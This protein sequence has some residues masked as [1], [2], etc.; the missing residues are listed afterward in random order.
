MPGGGEF[1]KMEMD[2]AIPREGTEEASVVP[3]V[4]VKNASSLIIRQA[5]VQ[6]VHK[7]SALINEFASSKVMLARGPQYLYEHIMD[8]IVATAPRAD[9]QPGQV[10]VGCGSARVLWDD[11]AEFRS[12]AVHPACQRSGLGRRIV[13]ELVRRSRAVGIHKVFVFTLAVEFFSSCGF[14]RVPR[15]KMPRIVWVECSKCPKFYRCDEVA[16]V[17]NI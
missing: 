3:D 15:D 17:R 12:V 1:S 10:V 2:I 4:A 16:M 13:D 6:D 7:M 8:Y 5:T 11:F 9:G 14:V